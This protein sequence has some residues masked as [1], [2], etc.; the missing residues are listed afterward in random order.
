MGAGKMWVNLNES[1]VTV[2]SIRKTWD[3]FNLKIR[4]RMKKWLVLG[5]L[6]AVT[7]A[8]YAGTEVKSPRPDHVILIGLDAMSPR[9]IQKAVTPNMNK[10][11]AG[12]AS[13]FN[14]RCV[15]SP[16]S[17]QNW[18]SML[19]GAVPLQHGVTGNPW[20]RNNRRIRPVITGKEDVFPSVFEWIREQRPDSKI[21]SFYEWRSVMRMFV[22]SVMDV[23]EKKATG[24]ES[25]R[26]G[27]EAFFE[28]KPDFLFINILET[29]HI[30]HVK[31]H[32]TDDYY[33]CIEKYDALIGEFADRIEKAGMWDRT[34]MMVVA[35]HGGF[36]GTHSGESPEATEIPVI[37]YG[38]GVAK[39]KTIPYYFIFDVAPT[40]AWLLGVTPPEVCVGKPLTTAFTERDK[41]F[42]YSP[43]PRLSVNEDLYEEGITVGIS[44]D[45]PEAEIRYTLDG[46]LPTSRSALYV[47]PLKISKN[48]LLQAV[49]FRDGYPS[50]PARAHYRFV[51]DG[52]P[53]VNYAYYVDTCSIFVPDFAGMKPV[54]TGKTYEID[55]RG[56]PDRETRFS[57]R[58]D[59]RIEVPADGK[60]R[61]HTR[62]DDGCWL[63]IDGKLVM[64]TST[65]HFQEAYGDVELSAG[66]HRIEVGYRQDVKRKHLSVY[67]AGPGVEA[68]ERLLTSEYFR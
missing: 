60:Y 44:A 27:M 23:C 3:V 11:I 37:L 50:R 22:T 55:L 26:S 35:D 52:R 58:F 32:D 10:L 43:M 41:T 54:V 39:G 28:D 1:Q 51:T 48:T 16:A 42:T 24:V 56:I 30:G 53:L 31:G 21:Y 6:L 46:S 49:A 64:K 18:T 2:L 15:L 25:F 45:W 57:V 62:S 17:T 14:G 5:V 19:T 29:D 67:M 66:I 9:G 4:R 63:K 34:V 38:K 61:F 33:R 7:G 12:G 47:N 40:V 59:A 68:P 20:Q 65:P 36:L 8:A 13:C